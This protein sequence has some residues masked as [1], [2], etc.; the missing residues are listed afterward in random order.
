MDLRLRLVARPAVFDVTH[1]LLHRPMM[2]CINSLTCPLNR[3]MAIVHPLRPRMSRRTAL[4]VIAFIWTSSGC[5]AL[6]YF[7][8]SKTRPYR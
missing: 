2:R 1:L 6:P 4:V 8:Y 7:I 3:Y 5:L